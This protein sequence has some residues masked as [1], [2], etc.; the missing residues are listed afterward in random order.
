[1]NIH[2]FSTICLDEDEYPDLNLYRHYIDHYK[3]LGIQDEN[4]HIVPCGVD[5]Y[6]ETFEDFE[7]INKQNNILTLDLVP[8]K[9]DVWKSHYIYLEWYKKI[10]PDDWIVRPDP[11]EFNDYGHFNTIQDCATYLEKNNYK[12]L[13]G[14]LMDRVSKDLY[15]N[16][17]RYPDELFAQFPVQANITKH[18]LSATWEKL[19][20]FKATVPIRPGHHDMIWNPDKI[21]ITQKSKQY[22]VRTPRPTPGIYDTNFKVF[23]FKWTSTLVDRLNNIKHKNLYSSFSRDKEKTNN[24]ITGDRFNIIIQ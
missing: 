5:S 17:V 7:Q 22:W 1:M 19:L 23:H 8:K 24:I 15:L 20:L 13:R 6:K 21:K 3:K 18:A 10:N 4:F 14:S 16:K 2:L 11:D 9:Y 12:A